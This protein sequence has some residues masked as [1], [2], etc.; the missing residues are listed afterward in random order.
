LELWH[1]QMHVTWQPQCLLW[2][3]LKSVK[4]CDDS[5][6]VHITQDWICSIPSCYIAVCGS[7]A[8]V[9]RPAVDSAASVPGFWQPM[10]NPM[11]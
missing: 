5:F 8:C 7:C 9:R 3:S 1:G 11:H 2:H 10:L 6:R 4:S